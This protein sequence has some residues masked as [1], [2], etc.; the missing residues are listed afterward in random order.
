MEEICRYSN[1]YENANANETTTSAYANATIIATVKHT[2]TDK[3]YIYVK[4]I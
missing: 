3:L 4:N 2:T 1:Q